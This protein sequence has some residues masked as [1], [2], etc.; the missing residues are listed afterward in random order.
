V[1]DP[2]DRDAHIQQP[3]HFPETNRTMLAI[4]TI[5]GKRQ[6]RGTNGLVLKYDRPLRQ[7]QRTS[8][9]LLAVMLRPVPRS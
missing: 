4:P 9:F 5:D 6:P 3:S 8:T 1:T 7:D 2:A